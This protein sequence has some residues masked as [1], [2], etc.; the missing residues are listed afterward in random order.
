VELGKKKHERK[1]L[2]GFN[3]GIH[4]QGDKTSSPGRR[5]SRKVGRKQ[6]K[7]KKNRLSVKNLA[8]EGKKGGD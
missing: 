4:Q 6:D 7:E 2:K 3:R 5:A 8:S 1:L